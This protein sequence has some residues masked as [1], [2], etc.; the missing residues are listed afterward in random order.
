MLQ[1]EV[2]YLKLLYKLEADYRQINQSNVLVSTTE[3]HELPPSPCLA[4]NKREI[5]LQYNF[6]KLQINPGNDVQTY[7]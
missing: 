1:E 7:C 3:N 4:G 5:T 6:Y 2:L